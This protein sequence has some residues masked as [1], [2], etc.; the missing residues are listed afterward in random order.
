MKAKFTL[1]LVVL[2]LTI[3]SSAQL[4]YLAGVLEAGQETSSVTSTASGVVIVK[5]NTATNFLQLVGNYRNLTATISG[6]HIHGPAAA[7]ANAGILFDLTNSGGTTGTLNGTATLTEAQEADLL[8]GNMYTNV[9]ST[10]T[11]AGGEIRAQLLATTDGQTEYLV[12]RMQGAQSTPPNNSLGSGMAYALVDKGTHW[13]Y[14][15]GSY[16]GL[17]ANASN[18]HIHTGAPHASGGVIVPLIFTPT[19]TGT[20]DT[21]Q[22]LS[23][24]NETAILSGDT[25]VNVHTS[26]YPLG[27]IR[28]QLTQ[29]SQMWFFANALEG[30]QEFPA[31]AST[32]RG[33]VI[34]KYNSVTNVLDLVGDYQ[35][36]NATV[37]GSHI[38]GPAGAGANAGI[39][40][41]VTNSGGT[42]GTLTGTFTLTEAQE[43]DLL[44]GNMYANVHSTGTYGAGE[45]RAQLLLTSMDNTQYITGLLE[46]SQSVATPAVVSPGTG[47]VT[48]LLDRT[49]L[50]IYVT[51]SFSGLTSNITNTHIHGGAAG[52][53]GPVVVPLFFGGTT[54]GTITGTA[55]VRATFADSVINGLSY[56]NI[57]TANYIPGEIRAQLGNLV[58]PLKLTAFNAYKDH[59]KIALMWESAEESNLSHY[60]VQQQDAA[61]AQWITKK[62]VTAFNNGL[63]NKYSCYDL[64]L[65][66]TGNYVFYRLK[67]VDKDGKYS[68]SQIIRINNLQV[69]AELQL[70]SNPVRNDKLEYIIT[71]IPTNKK[72]IVSI[73]DY[74]G[75][76]MLK[77]TVSTLY[78]NS[79][80]VGNLSAGMYKI[81]VRIDGIKLQQGFIK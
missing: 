72:A 18:A 21:A 78:N 11:Y 4:R 71:G 31:N 12:A 54:S 8:A 26:T 14:L 43:A 22:V 2:F 28:G 9:H 37:S 80:P 58:L 38:H 81:I 35:N 53:N 70:L 75:R 46:A 65:P 39:L 45:I 23:G 56:A 16:S 60:E 17:T 15:T 49:A 47:T 62:S 55:T 67:M 10:G 51:G 7:G 52:T 24:A 34:A 40:F 33:T 68:Y 3:A 25:Y 64:P 57:H 79:I 13:L 5:Y 27:E 32:A 6:S 30:S 73:L 63:N 59:E 29:L 77:T 41:D 66:G 44:S 61:T 69:K 50:K 20:V 74:N 76:L 36:L 19:A 42:T 1:V 48:V